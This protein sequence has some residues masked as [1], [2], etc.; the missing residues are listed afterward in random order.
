[1]KPEGDAGPSRIP[2]KDEKRN[3]KRKR[4]ATTK[5]PTILVPDNPSSPSKTKA[6]R[7][8]EKY[9]EWRQRKR[10]KERATQHVDSDPTT[11]IPLPLNPQ[12]PA[13]DD[14]A[15][16][17]MFTTSTGKL[18]TSQNVG[19]ILTKYLQ[20]FQK[21]P[22]KFV[23]RYEYTLTPPEVVNPKWKPDPNNPHQPPPDSLNSCT[24]YMP[25]EIEP[26]HV[27]ST[28]PGFRSKSLAKRDAMA[29]MVKRLMEVGRITQDLVPIPHGVEEKTVGAKDRKDLKWFEHQEKLG[30]ISSPDALVE[31]TTLNQRWA[32]FKTGV[33]DRLPTMPESEDGRKGIADYVPVITPAFW[34]NLPSFGT[35]GTNID[36]FPTLFELKIDGCADECRIICVLTTRPIPSFDLSDTCP[37][38][39]VSGSDKE[40]MREGEMD[41]SREID[42]S[43]R[44]KENTSIKPVIAR[45]I[46]R[47]GPPMTKLSESQLSKAL[48][49]T[50]TILNTHLA[51]PVTGDLTTCRWLVLPTQ[52]GFDPKKHSKIKRKHIDWDQ[53][54]SGIKLE[55]IPFPLDLLDTLSDDALSET[56]FGVSDLNR[57]I[58]IHRAHKDFEGSLAGSVALPGRKGGLVNELASTTVPVPD[59]KDIRARHPISASVYRTTSMLPTMF[60]HIDS[61]LIARQASETIFSSAVNPSSALLALTPRKTS[62]DLHHSYERLE[63]LGDT[64]L[65]L[66]GTIDVFARPPE[67]LR[68]VEVE[69]ER[70]LM[71]SN[72]MLHK[73]GED[74]GI[75]PYIRNRRFTPASWMPHGWSLENGQVVEVPPQTL[76]LKVCLFAQFEQP[77]LII[78]VVADVV[79]AF[80]GAAYLSRSRSLDS[81]I[82]AILDLHIPITAIKT[83]SDAAAASARDMEPAAPAPVETEGWLGAL[84]KPSLT[85]LGYKFRDPFKGQFVLVSQPNHWCFGNGN[86]GHVFGRRSVMG[87]GDAGDVFGGFA[88]RSRDGQWKCWRRLSWIW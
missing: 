70:H 28:P 30:K 54:E 20:A 25:K 55:P 11:P 53:V 23:A 38:R 41:L 88:R 24:I 49:F 66:V 47:T 82:K 64:L 40:H 80:I 39:H 7:N 26:N 73:C 57:L 76:G 61:I 9:Q 45:V 84:A 29:V 17:V 31:G 44:A 48:M 35:S 62:E 85:V 3:T 12:D 59:L 74:A 32:A 16:E 27:R 83:W 72:R 79:E 22:E 69:K 14:M 68:N 65:K 71:L 77:E 50:R 8:R 43:I 34:V 60:H 56:M 86:D 78:Q 58:H 15:I 46:L 33:R 18:V 37:I 52:R 21:N 75:P 67:V 1:M 42:L 4:I 2:I 81:A 10:Q 19:I 13:D 51:Q 5:T 6:E 36:L 87:N 63:F